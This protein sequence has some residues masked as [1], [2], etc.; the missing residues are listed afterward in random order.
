MGTAAFWCSEEAVTVACASR[1]RF[2]LLPHVARTHLAIL[3]W[4]PSGSLTLSLKSAD[5]KTQCIRQ[6][7]VS[8]GPG[9]VLVEELTR[10]LGHWTENSA[11]EVFKVTAGHR[12][13]GV[14]RDSNW[15]LPLQSRHRCPSVRVSGMSA[16]GSHRPPGHVSPTCCRASGL[17]LGLGLSVTASTGPR[18]PR[19]SVPC[20]GFARDSQASV[21][22]RELMCSSMKWGGDGTVR[23]G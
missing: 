18:G 8:T 9:R 23:L 2:G 13:C 17:L 20:F 12:C 11:G 1:E 4:A 15:L 22:R 14:S 16:G 7:R 3:L 21:Q 6:R 19:S 5:H 10:G